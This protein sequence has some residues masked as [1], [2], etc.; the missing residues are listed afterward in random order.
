MSELKD[1]ITSYNNLPFSDRIVF[2][3]T[4]SNDI[5]IS[6][7]LQSFL[8]ETRFASEG[9]CIY[10]H[11]KHVVKNGKRKDGIQRY[12][13]RECHRS[14]IPSSDSIT[15]RTRKSITVWAAYYFPTSFPA[16]RRMDAVQNRTMFFAT[17]R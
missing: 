5:T 15:S 4:I 9:L 13:C 7:D 17:R 2:F 11:G 16:C 6:D 14:F 3:T 1:I 8:V 12:L 10:C